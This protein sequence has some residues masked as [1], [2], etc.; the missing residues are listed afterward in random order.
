MGGMTLT[1]ASSVVVIGIIACFLTHV[2]LGFAPCQRVL[3]SNAAKKNKNICMMM[4]EDFRPPEPRKFYVRPDNLGN[5]A[6]ATPPTLLRLG[7]GVFM[8]GYEFSLQPIEEGDEGE[9]NFVRVNGRKLVEK[10]ASMPRPE[11]PLEIYEFES[12]PFCKKVREAAHIFDLD[13]LFYPCPKDSPTYRPKVMEMG[14][15]AQF[16]YLVDPNTGVAMYESDD[17]IKYM[18]DNYGDGKI[19]N[20]LQGVGSTITAGLG[21]I[22]RAGKGSKYVK[23]SIPEQPLEFW[24]YEGSPFTKVV[25]ERLVELELPHLYRTAARGSP[26]RQ[27]LKDRTGRFQVPYLEDPNTG[28]KMFESAEIV[29]YLDNTYMVL[30]Q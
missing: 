3:P 27:A 29:E 12:C 5:I 28:V 10:G 22:F 17:I 25:R 20:S 4:S 14:G 23:A 6:L 7:S 13:I 8:K 18:A 21:S 11:L 2:T 30:Q 9:Y 19:P 26:T 16:P 15:K 24:G 1:V